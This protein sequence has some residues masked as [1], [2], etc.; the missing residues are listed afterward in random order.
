MTEQEEEKEYGVT[1]LKIK[2]K[3]IE[4]G[5]YTKKYLIYDEFE[6][7]SNDPRVKKYIEEAIS[8]VKGTVESVIISAKREV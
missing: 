4:D 2:I 8:E 3:T 5:S 6:F 7:S 1:E